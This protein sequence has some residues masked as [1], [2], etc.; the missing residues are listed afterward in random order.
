MK[1]ISVIV[2]E[3]PLNSV[4]NSEALRMALSLTLKEHQ[5]RV[6]F[7]EDGVYTLLPLSAPRVGFTDMDQ[8]L[9]SLVELQVPL[10]AEREAVE[11]RGLKGLRYDPTLADR[12]T[13]LSSL[14]DEWVT[15]GF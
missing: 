10:I 8:Y 12:E 1:G 13:I 5:V 9:E 7:V 3:S 15:I 4:K 11:A 14:T 6:L 2:R